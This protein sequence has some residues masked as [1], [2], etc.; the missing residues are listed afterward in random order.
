MEHGSTR[1]H[2]VAT[3]RFNSRGTDKLEFSFKGK[4]GVL[5]KTSPN[6]QETFRQTHQEKKEDEN[7]PDYVRLDRRRFTKGGKVGTSS[8]KIIEQLANKTKTKKIV[9]EWGVKNKVVINPD[10]QV[11]PCCY[12]C[13]PHFYNKNDPEVRK[14][15]IE[16]SSY[17]RVSKI[18]K[19]T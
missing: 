5:E 8:K 17:A 1:H 16:T 18:S 3:D 9:C 7:R 10:G 2:F 15:F 12:F 19:R 4:K 11:L 14:W 13:N 6:W